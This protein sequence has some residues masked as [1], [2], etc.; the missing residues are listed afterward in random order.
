[1][2]KSHHD[3]IHDILSQQQQLNQTREKV[4]RF[5]NR[6]I[7]IVSGDYGIREEIKAHLET[8]GFLH[9]HVKASNSPFELQTF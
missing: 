2:Q 7:F 5:L 9:G 8:L 3:E 6:N 1:M 4:S